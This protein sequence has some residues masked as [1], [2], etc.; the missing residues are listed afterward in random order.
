MKAFIEKQKEYIEDCIVHIEKTPFYKILAKETI[1]T[2]IE[3][4]DIIINAT[5]YSYNMTCES[6]KRNF[7]KGIEMKE[8]VQKFRNWL[9]ITLNVLE[10][11]NA[12]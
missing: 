3:W 5:L 1:K 4:C 8:D 2:N 9:N 10:K 6:C 12:Q 11:E 7:G